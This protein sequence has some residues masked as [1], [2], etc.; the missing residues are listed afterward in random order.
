[1]KTNLATLALA[2]LSAGGASAAPFQILVY[3]S[4]ADLAV[5]GDTAAA[6][7]AQREAYWQA[8]QAY[9]AALQTAGV[10]RGGAALH[11]SAA[12][13]AV[14]VNA[15]QTEVAREPVARS[16]TELGGYFVIEVDSLDDAVA[17][18]ARAPAAARG[19]AAEVRPLYPVPGMSAAR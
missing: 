16:A 10:L 11:G 1:M 14:R 18:A 3:E 17:W 2:L 8:Y 13:R 6:G 15:G 5:R 9:G 7:G 4:P 12:A 19:G